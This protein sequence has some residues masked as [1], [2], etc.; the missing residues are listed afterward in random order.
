MQERVRDHLEAKDLQSIPG[1]LHGSEDIF[2]GCNEGDVYLCSH[3]LPQF[4]ITRL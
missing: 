1:S 3:R 2:G 4:T